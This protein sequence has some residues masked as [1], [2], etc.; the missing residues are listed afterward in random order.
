MILR[1][2]NLI[3][4]ASCGTQNAA[5][6]WVRAVSLPPSLL[7]NRLKDAWAVLFNERVF[8]VHWPEAGEF[9]Q[10]MSRDP[11]EGPERKPRNPAGGPVPGVNATL[12]TQ[13]SSVKAA[14]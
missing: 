7:K 8:A 13:L 1:L 3:P 2:R 10:A 14:S 11:D 4:S 9:E 6:L 12:G 5:G